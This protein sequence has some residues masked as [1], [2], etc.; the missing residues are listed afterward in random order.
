[1][2]KVKVNC[3]ESSEKPFL[4]IDNHSAHRSNRVKE[5]L[6]ANFTLLFMPPYS[7]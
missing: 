4:V 2:Q 7:C 1:M 6:E 5:Y 3:K